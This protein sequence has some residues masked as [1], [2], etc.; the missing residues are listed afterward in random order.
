MRTIDRDIPIT[1]VHAKRGKLTRAEPIA[2]LY[3]QGRVSH[4][5][6]FEKLEDQLCSYAPG[7]SDSPDRLDA[8][9]YALSECMTCAPRRFFCLLDCNMN[10]TPS[11]Y[12]VWFALGGVSAAVFVGFPTYRVCFGEASRAASAEAT[13][14]GT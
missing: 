2:S 1:R 11:D 8:C 10:S 5:G 7:T 13:V 9:V 6:M 3:E 4:V 12:L 14:S